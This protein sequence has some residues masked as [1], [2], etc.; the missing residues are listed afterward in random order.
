MRIVSLDLETSGL[1]PVRHRTLSIGAV[2]VLTSADFYAELRWEELLVTAQAMQINRID[3]SRQASPPGA[4]RHLRKLP[5]SDA[6]LDFRGWLGALGGRRPE[7][8]LRA[9]GKNTASLD[10]PFLRS[11]WAAAGAGDFPFSHRCV[12]LNSIFAAIA[13]AAG[14]DTQ[15]VRG[16]VSGRAWRAFRAAQ[17]GLFAELEAAGGVEHH[18]LGDAWWNAY[19]WEECLR[20]MR[21]SAAS[22][23]G[24]TIEACMAIA[25][26]QRQRILANPDDPSWTEH[27]AEVISAMATLKPRGP[28]QAD[29]TTPLGEELAFFDSKRTEWLAHHRGKFT[30]IRG[31][32]VAGFYDAAESAYVEGVRLWGNVP[33]LVKP[34]LPVDIPALVRGLIEAGVPATCSAV[35]G[36]P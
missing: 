25:E 13:C 10:L 12:D 32:K 29:A 24:R 4:P 5:A 11:A 2:D 27:L 14:L 7:E 33:F 36:G 22:A 28:E 6:V 8:E 3:L 20:L 31:E 26:A 21:S 34:V 9:M 16:E 17:P 18:G 19:A 23:S 1:D 15:Q 30:L 35:R